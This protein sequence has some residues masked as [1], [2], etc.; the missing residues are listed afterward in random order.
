[1]NSEVGFCLPCRAAAAAG[2]G[3]GGRAL[4]SVPGCRNLHA[5][6]AMLPRG[7]LRYVCTGAGS[8]PKVQDVHQ[9]FQAMGCA[10]LVNEED[11]NC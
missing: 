1:M 2:G 5:V 9:I 10:H 11:L 8:M 6:L 3:G 7:M 4:R